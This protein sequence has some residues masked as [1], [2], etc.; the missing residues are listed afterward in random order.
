MLKK[1]FGIHIE[2]E[3]ILYLYYSKDPERMLRIIE[4]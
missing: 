4:F 3:N 2:K 1:K